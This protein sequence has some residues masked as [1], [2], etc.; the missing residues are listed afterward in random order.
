MSLDIECFAYIK[1]DWNIKFHVPRH[2]YGFI[3]LGGVMVLLA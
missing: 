3:G 2:V 1:M